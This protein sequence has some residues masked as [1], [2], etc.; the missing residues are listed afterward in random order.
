M[1]NY[2]KIRNKVTTDILEIIFKAQASHLGSALSCV[3]ILI[4]LYF[5]ILK[6][7]PHQ[8]LAGNRDRFILSKGHAIA[9]LDAVLAER[10][11]FDKKLLKEYCTDGSKLLGHAHYNSVPGIEVSSGSL[12]HG[13]SIANGMA[14]A[15][16]RDKKKY[17]IFVLLSDGEC[18]EGSTWEAILFASHHKLDN[19][20]VIIDYNGWQA[21]GRIKEVL[22]LEPFTKKWRDFGWSVKEVDGHNSY[23]IYSALRNIPFQKN[24][25]SVLIAHTIKAKGIPS[26]EDKLESHYRLPTPE[27]YNKLINDLK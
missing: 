5:R 25:P 23:D 9:A 8:P 16:K 7:N 17:R 12:G 22:N 26:L 27:E 19:L 1:F 18:D 11:F 10:G 2:A 15:A 14:L 13:L 3:D 24:K 20:V 6:I 21:L 4:V